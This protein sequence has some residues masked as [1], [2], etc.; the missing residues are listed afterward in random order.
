MQAK[1][2]EAKKIIFSKQI[3]SNIL[4]IVYIY[5]IY[6]FIDVCMSVWVHRCL[7][8]YVYE[9]MWLLVE[10]L[11]WNSPFSRVDWIKKAN[12]KFTTTT[13]SIELFQKHVNNNQKYSYT[14][15]VVVLCCFSCFLSFV[16][17]FPLI[18][19]PSSSCFASQLVVC[20]DCNVCKLS[21]VCFV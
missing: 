14:F 9:C 6:T 3:L 10:T 5:N 2:W 19:L 1:K 17:F 15:D 21:F 20:C 4:Y 18:V 13:M 7:C 11:T 8:V 12:R 16:I